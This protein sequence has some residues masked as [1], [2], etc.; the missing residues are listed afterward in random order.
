MS[1]FDW[2][3]LPLA[4]RILGACGVLLFIDLLF[5]WQGVSIL[6]TTVGVSGWHGANGLLLGI[7]VTA[8]VVFEVVRLLGDRAAAAR[9]LV[10]VPDAL[11]STALA[12]T[13]LVLGV[14]KFLTAH[15]LRRWPEYVGLV[16]AVAI[17]Y[18]GWLARSRS[19]AESPEP[20]RAPGA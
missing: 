13:V 14:L 1:A 3:G 20:A 11:A 16:L 7:A 10:A 2:R 9:A 18:G 4:E 15:Q 12:G 6:G 5:T 17:G 8:L 19:T